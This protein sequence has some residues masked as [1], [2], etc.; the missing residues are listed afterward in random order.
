[1]KRRYT[2][3]LP[4][5]F[6]LPA[7]PA[8]AQTAIGG[9]ACTSSALNGTYEF[10]LSGRQVSAS[11]AV[12]KVFQAVGTAA[13]DGLSRVTLTMTANVVGPSQSFGTPLVYMGSYS[14]QSNCVGSMSITSGDAATFAL[15]ALS[16][17]G[18]TQLASSFRAVTTPQVPCASMVTTE[19]CVP[20]PLRRLSS[21]GATQYFS[22]AGVSEGLSV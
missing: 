8:L 5:L 16:V 14:L 6:C 2:T 18:A 9:G 11:G 15:E 1:M 20:G 7:M 4:I 22:P 10:L 17:N 21:A 13:F 12:S 3:L 19:Y